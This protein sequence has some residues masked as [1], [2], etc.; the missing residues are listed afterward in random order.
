MRP[1]TS[2]RQPIIAGARREHLADLLRRWRRQPRKRSLLLFWL[3]LSLALISD[4][5]LLVFGV[6]LLGIS[7]EIASPPADRHIHVPFAADRALWEP[8]RHWVIRADGRTQLF[9][10]FSREAVRRITGDER[11]EGR[12][13]LAVVVSWM[14]DRDA[15]ALKW[16]DYPCLSCEDAELRAIL[17][18][19]GRSPSKM[20][21]TEQL[22]GRFVEP[23]VVSASQ[24]FREILRGVRAKSGGGGDIPLSS[25]ERQAVELQDR[26][27]RFEEIGED[28]V[29]GGNSDEMQTARAAL[30][31]TYCSGVKDFFAAGLND[32]LAASRSAMRIEQ[33]SEDG[34]RLACEAWLNEHAPVWKAMVLSLLGL[35]LFTAAA[36]VRNRRPRWRRW[37]LLSG[38]LACLGCLGWASAA[39]VCQTIREGAVPI[40]EAT[41]GILRAA[42]LVMGLSLCLALLGRDAFLGWTGALLSSVGF[43]WA[44]HWPAAFPE[45]WPTLPEGFA[46]DNR[47]RMQVLLLLSAY[48]ALILA[49]AVAVLTLRRI[50]LAPP[51]GERVRRLAS[52][53]LGPIRFGVVLLTASAIVDGCA[54]WYSAPPGADGTRKRWGRFSSCRFARSCSTR[55]DADGFNR[56][57]S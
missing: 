35:G 22:H 57:L 55:D 33:N 30:C 43:L 15:N 27:T 32:F 47:L 53:C 40:N 23:S 11:F 12:D 5:L 29:D 25:L 16:D 50:L 1:K 7:H 26:L 39:I 51:N 9:E 8:L 54:H 18:R 4:I 44:N 19:E 41:Q 6:R 36:I 34:R 48:A 20:S 46:D 28:G 56:S 2:V 52:H 24:S 49:W 21:C 37:L 45:H 38:L 14:L 13:P 17:Y 3:L 42:S 31:D 10:S